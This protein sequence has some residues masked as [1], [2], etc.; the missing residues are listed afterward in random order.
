MKVK[1]PAT[2]HTMKAPLFALL[3]AVTLFSTAGCGKT[4]PPGCHLSALF[5][6]NSV[7]TV[8]VGDPVMMA[9]Y[10]IGQVEAI[11]LDPALPGTIIRMKINQSAVV[12]TDSVASIN[13]TGSPGRSCLTLSGGSATAPAITEGSILMSSE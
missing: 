5:K 10:Q 9:G 4:T 13:A 11:V 12:K 1:S 8:R 6:S 3:A 7:R 2:N